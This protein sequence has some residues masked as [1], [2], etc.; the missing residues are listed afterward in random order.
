[1]PRKM[2]SLI[3]SGLIVVVVAAIVSHSLASWIGIRTQAI[4]RS[5]FGLVTGVSPAF[6]GGSSLT[7]YGLDWQQIS[8]NWNYP[9]ASFGVPS[10]SVNELEGF[11]PFATNSRLSIIGVSVYDL[12]EGFLC[13][14]RAEIVPLGQTLR[15]LKSAHSDWT[16]GKR[17]L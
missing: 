12:N 15:D 13:D 2:R 7:F 6:L 5:T 4:S 1:M 17:V 3:F 8:T 14:Y 16:F 10:A 11:Q 9:I